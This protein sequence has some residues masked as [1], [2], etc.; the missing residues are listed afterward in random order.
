MNE[1]LLD[2]FERWHV[3][4]ETAFGFC[5]C[6]GL[7]PR[8][9]NRNLCIGCPHL[10]PNPEKR[11]VAVIWRETYARQAEELEKAGATDDALQARMRVQGLDD[12]IRT[13]DLMQQ[14]IDDGTYTPPFNL[15]PGH[16]D[17]EEHL[18]A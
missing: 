7:C 8:G 18:D 17:Y 3:L 4:L 9:Y 14:A 10:I 12:L 15:P 2:V 1:D 6:V 11:P 13:M 16:R 5:G